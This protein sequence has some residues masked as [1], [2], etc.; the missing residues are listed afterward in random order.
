MMVGRELTNLFPYTKRQIGQS[1]LSVRGLTS[2]KFKDI[3]FD[4]N[5][6]ELVGVFGL[7]GAGRSEV[8]RGIFGLDPV[9]SGEVIIAG[10]KVRANTIDRIA[11]GLAFV[12]ENRKEEGLLLNKTVQEN[13]ALVSLDDRKKKLS[14]VDREQ[15]NALADR[16]VEHLKVKTHNVR[17]QLVGQLSGGNQ[18]KIVIGKWIAKKPRVFIL[19]EPTRGVDVGA[20]FEIYSRINELAEQ[21]SGVLMISSEIEELMGICDRILVMSNGYITADIPRD[22]FDQERIME[23]AIER[24]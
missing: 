2:E 13:L 12:T 5:E 23:F 22:Q 14:F 6:G 24:G 7:I 15:E 9:S 1:V 3:T 4:V 18:Q 16:I 17:T 21:R 11:E 20:K 19:D 8:A 10:K